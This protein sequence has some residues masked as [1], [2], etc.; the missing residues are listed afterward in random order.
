MDDPPGT[1]VLQR[2][3]YLSNVKTHSTHIELATL[4]QVV[5]QIT[6]WKGDKRFI[7]PPCKSLLQDIELVTL[8]YTLTNFHV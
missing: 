1:Q 4:F 6:T 3:G 8:D 2:Q 7:I 5:A